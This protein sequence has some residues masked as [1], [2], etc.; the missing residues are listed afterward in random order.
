MIY[1]LTRLKFNIDKIWTKLIIASYANR[2]RKGKP[3][4]LN[5]FGWGY[6]VHK[7]NT[8]SKE[9]K[10]KARKAKIVSK[11]LKGKYKRK[12]THKRPDIDISKGEDNFMKETKEFYKGLDK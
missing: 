4:I 10:F 7:K 12:P 11:I 3:T 8:K 2:I 5:M 1:W 6:L 9:A